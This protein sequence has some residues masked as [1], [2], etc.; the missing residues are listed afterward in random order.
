MR[1]LARSY[2]AYRSEVV[3][4][5]LSKAAAILNGSVTFDVAFFGF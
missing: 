5:G 2:R 1:R 3:L 4:F